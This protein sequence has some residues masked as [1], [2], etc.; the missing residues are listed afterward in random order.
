[1]TG[2][3]LDTRPAGAAERRIPQIRTSGLEWAPGRGAYLA[4]VRKG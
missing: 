3:C 2:T 1:M 4:T